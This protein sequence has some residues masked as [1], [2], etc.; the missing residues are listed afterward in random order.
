MIDKIEKLAPEGS[1]KFV[2]W[3]NAP[4]YKD[5]NADLDAAR[6]DHDKYVAR[7]KEY[8]VNYNGGK[9]I[10]A[11]PNKS[12]VK[13]MLIRKQ[14][15]W[16]YPVLE[17]PFLNTVS[18]FDVNP[19]TGEDEE[20][21]IQNAQLLNY[22]WNIKV[23]KVALVTKMVRNYED[24]GTAIIQTGWNAEYKDELV[25]VEK[26]VYAT[27][28]ESIM[29]LDMLVQNGEMT[30]EQRIEFLE[31]GQAMQKGTEIVQEVQSVLAENHV[32]YMVKDN[33]S[34]IVDPSCGDD[35]SAAGFIIC[36]YE[37]NISELKK[38][39]YEKDEETGEETGY[40]HNLSSLKGMQNEESQYKRIHGEDKLEDSFEYS[41]EAR[42]KL[43]AY[44]YW[45]Y[46]D[47]NDDNV[48]V[49]I[50]ATWIGTVLIRLE[51][52]PFPFK[53][54]PFDAAAN[55]PLKNNW[56]GEPSGVLI[57]DNQEQIGRM[58]RA[59]NDMVSRQA[60]GQTFISDQ[61]FPNRTEKDNYNDGKTTYYRHGMDPK[62]DIYREKVDSIDNT[63]MSV[64]A[65]NESQA[66]SLT[67]TKPFGSSGISTAGGA[68]G[69]RSATD[70]TAKREL[71]ALRRLSGSLMS[72]IGRKTIMMNQ[73]F[74]SEEQVIRI[75]NK[76]YVTIK[77][78]DIQGEFDLIVDVST[79]E[80]DNEKAQ[81]LGFIM[82][83][84]AATMD[85][86]LAQK[87]LGKIV[88]L[89]KE[90]GL[91]DDI[92]GFEHQPTEQEQEQHR[93]NMEEAS[94]RKKLLQMQILEMAKK[95]ENYD[96]NILEKTSRVEENARDTAEAQAHAELYLAQA[97]KLRSETDEIDKRYVDSSE[98]K[99]DRG[100]SEAE[101][102]AEHRLDKIA[103]RE[104]VAQ[105]KEDDH[106]RE[107]EKMH[108]AQRLRGSG[109]TN[110][111]SNQINGEM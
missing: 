19:R 91:A 64:I 23:D 29:M 51:K 99:L 17:E 28:E 30:P 82:Q 84:N 110:M 98:G 63:T 42:R 60:V 36:E 34:V 47:I 35:L 48:L 12:T 5:L 108:L 73:A 4:T 25:N 62:R 76:N 7:L 9:D 55:L 94:M 8:R 1:S 97:D 80:K 52:S 3:I 54:L 101:K 105:D 90:P 37:T 32:T 65:F 66:E 109:Q 85:P 69:V 78:E 44:E 2:D 92:E 70:A 14:S 68:T 67:G 75:T 11:L 43:T 86:K 46:W 41:D 16:R 18:L 53:G 61:F 38:H 89:K 79:P 13:S 103:E 49:P 95:I 24:E 45:G 81:D 100:M 39:E 93:A 50:V 15:E 106:Q 74:M 58:T 22:Q 40:Y 20:G 102:I 96:A 71:S 33:E 6:S 21:A 83:T 59:M 56:R 104:H 31:S 77:R 88:R 87:V 72:G 10:K 27:P 57:V 111:V 26:P 107:L